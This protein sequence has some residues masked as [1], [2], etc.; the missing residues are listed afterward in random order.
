MTRNNHTKRT[1]P[2]LTPEERRRLEEHSHVSQRTISRAYHCT[3]IQPATYARLVVSA[4][5]LG[6]ALPPC[7][8]AHSQNEFSNRRKALK[9]ALIKKKR[10]K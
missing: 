4:K 3:P 5:A 7:N 6:L 2:G 10:S 9:K 1:A 8:L